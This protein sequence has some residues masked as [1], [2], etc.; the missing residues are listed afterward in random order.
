M[1]IQACKSPV[2]LHRKLEAR[3]SKLNE[4]ISMMYM[5]IV[6]IWGNIGVNIITSNNCFN[7]FGSNIYPKSMF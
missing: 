5:Y 2:F 3:R 6:V 7:S 4:L 1:F